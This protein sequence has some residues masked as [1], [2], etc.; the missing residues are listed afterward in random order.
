MFGKRTA[1]QVAAQKKA[2]LA[3]AAARKKGN[4]TGNYAS[5]IAKQNA[6][7]N[8]TGIA[9]FFGPNTAKIEARDR[10]Q[11]DKAKAEL[12]VM[13]ERQRGKRLQ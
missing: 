3:S 1:K 11:R 7:A 2:A 13:L 4:G 8:K 5:I 9:K 10:K 6:R 12:Q